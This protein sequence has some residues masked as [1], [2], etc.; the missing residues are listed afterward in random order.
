MGLY[1]FILLVLKYDTCCFIRFDHL[2]EN[3]LA[4]RQITYLILQIFQ[5][6]QRLYQIILRIDI[7]KH[8]DRILL[9]HLSQR[10]F[11]ALGKG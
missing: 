10:H 8:H 11:A 4:D 5:T 3:G 1:H 2:I 6:H 7:L 9:D